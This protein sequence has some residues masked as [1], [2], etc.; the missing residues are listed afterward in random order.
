MHTFQ[1]TMDPAFTSPE[2]WGNN[3]DPAD[4]DPARRN[5]QKGLAEQVA[6]TYVGRAMQH[7]A[8]EVRDNIEE[9]TTRQ[10][11]LTEESKGVQDLHRVLTAGSGFANRLEDLSVQELESLR[12]ALLD[13]KVDPERH[14]EMLAGINMV[15]AQIDEA[16]ESRLSATLET[17][18]TEELATIKEALLDSKVDPER[19][20]A[21]YKH[22]AQIEEVI[23]IAQAPKEIMENIAKLAEL[24]RRVQDALKQR[25]FAIMTTYNQGLIRA[26]AD[27]HTALCTIRENNP[28]TLVDIVNKLPDTEQGLYK[29]ILINFA[30]THNS[31]RFSEEVVDGL[32][33]QAK[34]NATRYNK[35]NGGFAGSLLSAYRGP[36]SSDD[37]YTFILKTTRIP[38]HRFQ[39]IISSEMNKAA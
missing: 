25:D 7:H 30:S 37:A 3:A 16:I 10:F 12:E 8:E 23:N 11:S 26:A 14:A 13:S 19:H 29:S 39:Q 2:H 32:E 4:A 38:E 31:F 35:D 21:I 9:V 36:K 20:A 18:S 6:S 33:Y 15:I 34:I 28:D 17:A 1:L 27:L 22:I 5:E 24:N